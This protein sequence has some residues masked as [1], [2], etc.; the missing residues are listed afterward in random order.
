MNFQ[1]HNDH[2]IVLL[3]SNMS[4]I[5]NTIL[6]ILYNIYYE[7]LLVYLTELCIYEKIDR[8]KYYYKNNIIKEKNHLFF[9]KIACNKGNLNMV[10][11]LYEYKKYNLHDNDDYIIKNV[12]FNGNLNILK[13][14]LLMDTF[15]IHVDNDYCFRMSIKNEKFEVAKYLYHLAYT[16]DNRIFFSGIIE[17]EFFNACYSNKVS[18]AKFLYSLDNS[19]D[20][21]NY[22]DKVFY[23]TCYINNQDIV[24]FLGSICDEYYY[25][26]SR[27][28]IIDYG[29][30]N[31]V[32]D[33]FYRKEY[34]KIISKLGINKKQD[35]ILD[36][37]K[38]CTICFSED[39]NFITSCNHTFCLDCF[40]TW[41]IGHNKKECSYCRQNINIKNC[42]IKS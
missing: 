11:F 39:Y 17:H 27:Y 4:H 24:Y 34:D 25:T 42:F 18:I 15:D 1:Y 38:N 10:K 2:F 20:F 19:I 3:L 31:S 33:M 9:L 29:V 16:T 23:D 21:R 8:L 30:K 14:M 35:F 12:C 37:N 40:L 5:I 22:D 36:G 28:G 41:H 7:F 13:W 6:E 26:V 32:K